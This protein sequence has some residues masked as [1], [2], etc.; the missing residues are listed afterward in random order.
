[1]TKEPINIRYR[2]VHPGDPDNEVSFTVSI[3]P[4]TMEHAGHPVENPPYWARLDVEPCTHCALDHEVHHHCPLSLSVVELVE[5]FNPLLSF[6]EVDVIVETPERTFSK[7]TSTQKALSSLLGL[8]MA[9]SACP[10]M[11]LLKPMARFHLPFST[12]E[13]TI[14]RAASSYLLGQ[15]MLHQRGLPCDLALE[16]LHTA[17][18]KIHKVNMGMAK[19]LRSFARGDANINAIVLLDLFAHEMPSAIDLKMKNLEYLFASY[20]S[21]KTDEA[22]PPA[23]GETGE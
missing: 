4:D 17:Y 8:Y 14:Y 21:Q 23:V 1:M 5:T 13:E 2:F 7:R 15:Y 19:R 12:K 20:F 22:L 6:N 10:N 18:Q 3:D 9:T 16:G 11:G